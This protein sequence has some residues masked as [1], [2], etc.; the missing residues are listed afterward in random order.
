MYRVKVLDVG[1]KLANKWCFKND[2]SIIDNDEYEKNKEYVEII[3]IIDKQKEDEGQNLANN[4]EDILE[5]QNIDGT[6]NNEDNNENVLEND[7]DEELEALKERAKE[8]GINITHNMKKETIIKKIEEAT[9][10]EQ[11][12]DK[13][14]NLDGE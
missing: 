13:N 6:D 7:S 1:V 11:L 9:E 5:N 3:E 8:L 10:N 4:S 2:E 14:Q 12:G